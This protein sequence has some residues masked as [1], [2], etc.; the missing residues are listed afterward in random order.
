[1]RKNS[2]HNIRAPIYSCCPSKSI[3]GNIC[4]FCL[5]PFLL[6]CAQNLLFH[7]LLILCAE[8]LK[9]L[10][11]KGVENSFLRLPLQ[12]IIQKQHILHNESVARLIHYA[13]FS[14]GFCNTI[15]AQKSNTHSSNEAAFCSRA[16]ASCGVL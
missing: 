15:A 10:Q 5:Y 16:K 12:K 13:Y 14:C 1:M 3:V 9:F 8:F 2:L 6:D 11:K 4:K 7:A